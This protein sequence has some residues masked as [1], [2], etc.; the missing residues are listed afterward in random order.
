MQRLLCTL[1][2]QDAGSV[3]VEFAL[4]LTVVLMLTFGMIDLCRAVYTATVVQAA[5]QIGARAGIISI[6]AA[7]PAAQNRLLALDPNSAVITATLVNN[8]QVE[9][10]I[11]Y[12]FQLITPY[13]AQLVNGGSIQLTSSASSLM[14]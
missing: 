1:R 5:A 8:E 11:T 12:Q 7:V 14:Y 10:N 4:S 3:L 6:G 9:V 2:K 13:L